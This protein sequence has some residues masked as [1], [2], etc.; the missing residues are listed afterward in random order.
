MTEVLGFH[1]LALKCA[2]L[3]PMVTF[4]RDGLGL[5]EVDRHTDD[6]GLRSVWLSLAPGLLMLERSES[7]GPPD[8]TEFEDD[9]PGYHLMALRIAPA[10]RATYRGRLAALGH[11]VVHETV[12]TIYF[13]DP[14]GRRV[15]LSTL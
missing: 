15:G 12:Y 1:H 3:E 10:A 14:E 8:P 4:Y 7:S 13:R 6:R 5:P 2:N 11:P 9:P